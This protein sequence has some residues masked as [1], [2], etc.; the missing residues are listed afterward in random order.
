[1]KKIQ[2]IDL[3]AL[4]NTI[5][6]MIIIS[7]ED[8]KNFPQDEVYFDLVT[9]LGDLIRGENTILLRLERKKIIDHMN[10]N[11]GI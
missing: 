4:K 2:N 1:M 6:Q 11:G 7:L 5:T 3:E 9:G 10:D 8:E